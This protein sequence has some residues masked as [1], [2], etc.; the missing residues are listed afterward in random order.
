[1]KDYL[2][3]SKLLPK[4]SEGSFFRNVFTYALK[5]IAVF[6]G[7]IGLITWIGN[8]I[9]IFKM[10]VEGIIGGLLFQLV[11]VVAIYAVIHI[12]WI[13]S[14][15]IKKQEPGDYTII[16]IMSTMVRMSG[17]VAASFFVIFGVGG[18]IFIIFAGR[19]AMEI[20]DFMSSVG[21]LSSSF[22][23][24]I[25]FIIVMAIIAF[26]ALIIH[27]L[28]A[29][30]IVVLVDMARNLKAIRQSAEGTSLGSD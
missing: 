29:E 24:G 19:Q 18:G 5:V 20:I 10:N 13:R 4:L 3:M 17:E 7:I 12:I 6:V 16:P 26:I 14:D 21:S 25:M 11:F 1:M 2:F 9:L 22:L 28:I 23:A 8:W 15:D 30:L 27:Y